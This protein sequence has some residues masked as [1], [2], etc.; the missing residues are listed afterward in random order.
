[1]YWFVELDY[2]A[3]DDWALLNGGTSNVSVSLFPKSSTAT[4]TYVRSI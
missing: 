1:M 3:L 4:C 2:S